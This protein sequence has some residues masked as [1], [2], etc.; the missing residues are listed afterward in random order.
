MEIRLL[1]ASEIECRVQSVDKAKKWCTLLLY[2]DARVDMKLLDELFGSKNWQRTHEVINGQL[3]CNIDI[4]DPDKKC[5]VRKQDL[6]TESNTEAE[7][8]RASDAFKRAGF[9]WGIG[10]ELYTAPKIF[11]NLSEG[12]FLGDKIRTRFAVKSITYYDDRSIKEVVI[13]DNKGIQRYPNK[14]V[15]VSIEARKPVKTEV[16][17]TKRIFDPFLMEDKRF[18]PRILKRELESRQNGKAFS[19]AAMLE[20]AYTIDND[21]IQL[22]Y[23]KYEEYKKINKLN[24]A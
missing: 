14:P 21:T 4:W 3:F 22:V 23:S 20:Q 18:F 1:K 10:R 2:K 8:G 5:W 15:L 6:G 17:P 12:D 16:K 9:N 19:M 11:I 24:V 7:K 13:I